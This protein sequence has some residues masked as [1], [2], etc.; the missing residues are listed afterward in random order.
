MSFL[1]VNATAF[2]NMFFEIHNRNMQIRSLD[3]MSSLS[4][5]RQ[6]ERDRSVHLNRG[7]PQ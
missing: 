5:T 1:R 6:S 2:L 3:D 4:E 7:G